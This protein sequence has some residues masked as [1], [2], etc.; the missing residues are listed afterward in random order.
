M[1]N[2]Y[3]IST[4]AF[5]IFCL[6]GVSRWVDGGKRKLFPGMPSLTETF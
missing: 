1:G 2:P 4:A 3:N 5:S 6:A